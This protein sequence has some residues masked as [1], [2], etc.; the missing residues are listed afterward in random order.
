MHK[1]TDKHSRDTHARPNFATHKRV[2]PFGSDRSIV[3]QHPAVKDI[4]LGV[5]T[6]NNSHGG[7]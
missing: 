5:K 6:I 7:K 2:Q 4:E 3:H 1:T